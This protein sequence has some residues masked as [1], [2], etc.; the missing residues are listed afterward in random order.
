MHWLQTLY[1][2][3]AATLVPAL[4]KSAK[5]DS[6]SS[7]NCGNGRFSSA[8]AGYNTFSKPWSEQGLSNV[9]REVNVYL[10]AGYD[11]SD[12][13]PLPVV[14]IF[15]GWGERASQYYSR[16]DF[17]ALADRDNFI[18]V[19]PDGLGDCQS[20]AQCGS[21][22]SWNG[23][24]TTGSDNSRQAC[25][26]SVHTANYCYSSVVAK[27]GS[28]HP[29]DW[30]TGYN[31]AAF[32]GETLDDV[33]A[34][35]CVDESKVFAWGC[36]NGG[37]MTHELAQKLPGR[38]A[39]IAAGCGGKPHTGWE[40]DLPS[41]GA[42]ISMM[43]ISGRNDRTIPLET[44]PA[45]TN[46]W[47]GFLY[48]SVDA[49]TAAYKDYNG[50][51]NSGSRSYP[52]EYTASGMSCTEEGYQCSGD[53]SVVSCL[54]D[55]GHDVNTA[56]GSD[57]LQDEPQLAWSFFQSTFGG[58]PAPSPPSPPSPQPSPQPSPPAG[59]CT[60]NANF[61][62]CWANDGFCYR[63]ATCNGWSRN[64]CPG[65]CTADYAR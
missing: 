31:D 17:K 14:F 45:G 33:Q 24:G 8:G 13:T 23:V 32:I 6:A 27:Y 11:S 22:R 19:Y 59:G 37:L 26:T 9:N 18:V 56:T 41:G 35:F 1:I 65:N 16:Y 2:C 44:P 3:S 28:C 25:N 52:T 34:S 63:C 40:R 10:P 58:A 51:Q 53:V 46:W 64:R 29:C 50:C 38:F 62:Y 7:A 20:N 55:G 21:Y 48:A 54:F 39:A 15:G 36:S 30:T 4:R 12:T 60:C 61:P 49:T 42:P 43:L 57:S 47:D 5:R